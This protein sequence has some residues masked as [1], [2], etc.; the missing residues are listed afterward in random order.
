MFFDILKFAKKQHSGAY[1]TEERCKYNADEWPHRNAAE[2]A[3]IRAALGSVQKTDSPALPFGLASN[4]V[5]HMEWH[6]AA[7]WLSVAADRGDRDGMALLSALYALGLGV[8]QDV[9]RATYWLEQSGGTISMLLKTHPRQF[10]K[11][12]AGKEPMRVEVFRHI[13]DPENT[14]TWR[15]SAR[16]EGKVV[17][18]I[19]DPSDIEEMISQWS[20]P[21]WVNDSG[22]PNGGFYEQKAVCMAY[23]S[24]I[25]YE[26][27]CRQISSTASR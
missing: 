10:A 4:C 16:P 14:A 19:A 20:Q 5:A 8:Q 18:I 23:F 13:C 7:F 25:E 24:L 15:F 21:S 1:L 2:L 11:E 3:E 6:R 26:E 22:A 27:S 9:N 17:S 12:I